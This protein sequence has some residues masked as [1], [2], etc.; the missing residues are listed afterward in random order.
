MSTADSESRPAVELV[1]AAARNHVIGLNGQMPWHLPADLKYFRQLTLHHTV[2]MGRLTFASIGKA[3]PERRNIV[4]SRHALEAKGIE[5]CKGLD[6][7]LARCVGEERVFIIGGGQ[8]YREALPLA[9]RIY[10]TRVETELEG[11]TRFP[12]L[13]PL[14]WSVRTL[15]QQP[16]DERHQW[17]LRFLC[18]ERRLIASGSAA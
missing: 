12:E 16:A 6:E 17:P 10:L 13:D 4:L 14:Q 2:I 1:V 3:L 15:A 18:F 11:D 8:L 5:H 7:A 9:S